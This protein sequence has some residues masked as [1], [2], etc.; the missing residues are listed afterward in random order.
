MRV[1]GAIIQALVL[2]MLHTR[3]DL[4]L[5]SGVTAQLV[6][7]QYAGHILAALQQFT[8]ELLR[9]GLVAS[10]LD[11]DIQY[12]PMLINDTPE[13]MPYAI[14]FQKHLIQMPCI[15]RLSTTPT[16]LV[17]IHL[18]KLAGPLANRFIA[19]GNTALGEQFFHIPEAQRKR[20]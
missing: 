2:A 13:I 8:E 17:G 6:G 1:F 15:A 20:K 9:G 14:D 16:Q 18:P 5:R 4:L 12:D 10:A 11:K 19:H 7:N 3:H